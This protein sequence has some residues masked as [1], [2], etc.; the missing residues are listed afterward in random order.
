MNDANETQELLVDEVSKMHSRVV[1][2]EAEIEYIM[3]S[4]QRQTARYERHITKLAIINEIGRTIASATELD[5][6]LTE[7]HNQINRLF[8]AT[9]FCVSAYEETSDE[10]SNIFFVEGGQVKPSPNVRH[11]SETGFTGCMIRNRKSLLLQSGEEITTF[12]ESLGIEAIGKSALSWLGV[13]LIVADEVVGGMVVQSYDQEGLYDEQD[14]ALL[15][16]IAAQVAPALSNLQL[17]E[18]TRQRAEELA[19]L[20]ELGQA[21]T[22][23][24]NVEGV[25][26]EAYRQTSRLLDTGNF[27]IGL[28]NADEHEITFPL[29]ISESKIDQ[30]I[31]VIPADQ[32]ITGYIIHNREGVLI[33]KNVPQRLAE[34]G[35]EQVGEICLSFMGTPLIIG[36]RVLGVMGIQS[37]SHIAYNQRDFDLLTAIASPVAIALQNAQL[38][39]TVQQ[40]YAEVEKQ[41]EERTAE[42]QRETAQRER[43]QQEVIDAQKL[44]LQE[45]S[46]PIIPL[47][48]RIIVIPLIGS[49]DNERARDITRALLAGIREQRAK[50][51]IL[52]ITGVSIVDS[53]VVN[54]LN[55]TIHAARLKGA[56]AIVTGITDAV[57]E[58]IVDL[59]IDW[60]EV[61][62]LSDLQTG[63]R[64]ALATMG[65][66]IEG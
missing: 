63:L 35:V 62:T 64:T 61:T 56:H 41:V 8:H 25:L 36:D 54:H 46:T 47:M 38:Y 30:S 23:R 45:L 4:A 21:L 26:Q 42:L 3:T 39:E 65:Q 12:Q 48:E 43:L 7:V 20:N 57:A 10:W 13:P 28:Y 37:F 51:V 32:G 15:L 40:A 11:K 18:E 16:T 33:S 24:L 1:E 66:R 53:G 19:V 6:V 29:N 31:P 27:Y 44:A 50:I 17:L 59:G 60:S 5:N 55:K 49:I 34:L 22:A 2:L 58:S 14:E 52:D 9:N